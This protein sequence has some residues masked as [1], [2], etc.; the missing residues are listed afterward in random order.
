MATSKVILVDVKNDSVLSA[1][2]YSM[3]PQYNI[4]KQTI[5]DSEVRIVGHLAKSA[6]ILSPAYVKEHSNYLKFINNEYTL[7]PL[8]ISTTELQDFENKKRLVDSKFET[9]C[10]LLKLET[11]NLKECIVSIDFSESISYHLNTSKIEPSSGIK[12][13]A[14][15]NN[16]TTGEA[17]RELQFEYDEQQNKKMRIYSWHKK[18]ILDITQATS[19]NQL[20]SI[21]E[22]IVT[23]LWKD[24]LI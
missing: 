17:I 8:D 20:E 22:N 7:M 14:A 10:Q 15:I 13:Y 3:L 24:S 23:Q 4:L 5:L 11:Q 16:L 12:E 6:A 21:K 2:E 9:I 1:H 18:F 19:I